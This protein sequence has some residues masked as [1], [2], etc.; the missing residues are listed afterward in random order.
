MKCVLLMDDD[1]VWRTM[2]RQFFKAQGWR[3]I[4]A[5][6]GEEG[7]N[8]ARE[9]KPDLVICDLLMP[10]FNGIQVCR[11]IKS[12]KGDFP[13]TRIFIVTSSGYDMDRLSALE[14]GADLFL[15]KPV[16]PEQLLKA[17]NGSARQDSVPPARDNAALP[18][19]RVQETG[20]LIR[21]WGVRGSIPAPGPATVAIGGNT[22]CVELRADGELIVLDAGTGIRPLGLEL[23]K[24]FQGQALDFTLLI[25]HTHWDHIQGFPFFASAYNPKNT[26]R[27]LAYEGTK[28]GLEHTFQSQM[29]S[30]YFPITMHQM[31]SNISI[32]ELKEMEFKIRK[33]RVKATFTNHPG[34]CAAYRLFTSGGSIVYMPDNELFQGQLANG[35]DNPERQAYAARR[36][37]E[38]REFLRDADVLMIDSQ[39]DAQEYPRYVGWGHSSVE[40]SVRLAISANVRKYFLFH[41]DPTHNDQK[42]LSMVERARELVRQAGSNME[43]EAACEGMEIHLPARKAVAADLRTALT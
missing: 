42:I 37:E 35:S 26:I 19:A 23:S 17:L 20:A 39:F 25:T 18:Q 41:H 2:L 22:S 34:V 16:T 32:E 36:D 12:E 4:E 6:N 10:R 7:L 27:V 15:T 40:D 1:L 33:V 38:F 9:C 8:L 31:P 21:F 43:V 24:E 13:H 5:T 3:T 29:E 28:K 14:A 30:P 11:I